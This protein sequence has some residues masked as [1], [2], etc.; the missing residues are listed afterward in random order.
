MKRFLIIGLAALISLQISAQE[1]PDSV[2][3]D[4]DGDKWISCT[5][6]GITISVNTV[7]IRDHGKYHALNIAIENKSAAPVE[8]EPG[9]D[10]TASSYTQ[11]K[12]AET[13]LKVY[14]FEEFMAKYDKRSKLVNTLNTVNEAI[15]VIDGSTSSESYDIIDGYLDW[16]EAHGQTETYN[17]M[18]EEGRAIRQVGYFKSVTV[19][20]GEF[21]SG[22][23]YVERAKG[24]SMTVN[25]S[26][27]G[28]TYTYSWDL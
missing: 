13:Q 22:Y 26:I 27:N 12:D 3:F 21:I 1:Q 5:E 24:D 9:S 11:K 17:E 20:P 2:F 23:A 28:T 8:F 16:R 15:K 4:S 7:K 18:R 10:I 14:S 6:N 19:N 25:I